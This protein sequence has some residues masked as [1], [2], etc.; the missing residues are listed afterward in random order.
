MEQVGEASQSDSD[1]IERSSKKRKL[2]DSEQSYSDSSSPSDE[3]VDYPLF[4]CIYNSR[5]LAITVVTTLGM[6]KVTITTINI[7]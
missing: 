1:P 2:S 4:I 7:Y 6:M 3:E 5:S